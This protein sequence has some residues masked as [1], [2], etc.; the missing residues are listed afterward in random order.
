M[1]KILF[2]HYGGG[3]GG[4]PVSMINMI[5]SLDKSLYQPLA[6]F[7]EPGPILDFAKKLNVPTKVTPLKSAFFYSEHVKISFRMLFRYLAY[8]FSSIKK[9]KDLIK[10]E[11]PDIIYLNTSVLVT[12]AVGANFYNIPLVWHIREVP[13]INKISITTRKSPI[14]TKKKITSASILFNMLCQI[15]PFFQNLFQ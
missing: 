14:N 12:A 10:D 3:I 11:K 4:A 8:Y 2:I 13:G 1:K 6:I 15:Q 5:A 9:M 7:T